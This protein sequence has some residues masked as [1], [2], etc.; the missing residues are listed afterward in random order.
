MNRNFIFEFAVEE[1]F[2]TKNLE[3]TCTRLSIMPWRR[4]PLIESR[5]HALSFGMPKYFLFILVLT[6]LFLR[7]LRFRTQD[8][9]QIWVNNFLENCK[10]F[11]LKGL[12]LQREITTLDDLDSEILV[13][14]LGWWVRK[15]RFESHPLRIISW[16]LYAEEWNRE[17]STSSSVVYYCGPTIC[18][19]G[20]ISTNCY[21]FEYPIYSWKFDHHLL[22][23]LS[24]LYREGA[25]CKNNIQCK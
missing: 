4:G 11:S 24:A 25:H 22:L 9:P 17:I 21:L 5:Y 1:Y 2:C 23:K 7:R 13:N 20:E 19:F 18:K 12:G 10:R 16:V 3:D 8:D 6:H 14:T 15:L